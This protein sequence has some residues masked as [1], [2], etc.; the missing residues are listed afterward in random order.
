[1]K[2]LV[3]GAGGFVGRRLFAWL[4]GSAWAGS[5]QVAAPSAGF[6]VRDP[7]TILRTLDAVAP[8]A[9]LHLAAQSHVPTAW[10]D[11]G[12]T[13]H[14]NAVGTVNLCHALAERTFTGPVL[15]V[16]S[17]DVYGQVPPEALPIPESHAPAPRN[18]YA[19]SKV[20][21]EAGALQWWRGKGLRVVVAR[22]FNHTGPGQPADFVLPSLAR[23][24]ARAKLG[25]QD[26]VTVGDLSPTRDFT[27]VDDVL[28][29]YLGLLERGEAGEVYNV[30]SGREQKLRDL[31]DRLMAVAGLS[32]PV[33]VDP[34]RL[35][36]GDQPRVAGDPAKLIARLGKAPRPIGDDHLRAL[37]DHWVAQEDQK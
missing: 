21:A 26:G 1:M 28:D 3:T 27:W 20:A 33:R 4:P 8:D 7:S 15:V 18:P 24:V 23:Q 29:A 16:G 12:G 10:A 9:V 22:S 6:D 25:L 35:R 19:A 14:V 2:V 36:P 34:A 32:V 37:L 31:L 11:P 30:C 13:F 5:V 17:A